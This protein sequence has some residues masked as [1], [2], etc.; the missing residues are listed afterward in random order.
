MSFFSACGDLNGG[1]APRP[2]QGKEKYHGQYGKNGG[3]DYCLVCHPLS[4][5]HENILD[6]HLDLDLIRETIEL[7][8]SQSCEACHYNNDN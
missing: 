6:L 5:L 2:L 1:D 3:Y 7:Q 4:K 8:G